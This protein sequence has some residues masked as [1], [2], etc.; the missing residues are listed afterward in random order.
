MLNPNVVAVNYTIPYFPRFFSL[1]FYYSLSLHDQKNK[2]QQKK[3]P[4]RMYFCLYNTE[5]KQFKKTRTLG[6]V[7]QIHSMF[8]KLE[9]LWN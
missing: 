9:K 7:L 4:A 3:N 5:M 1:L 8:M 6:C 2:K